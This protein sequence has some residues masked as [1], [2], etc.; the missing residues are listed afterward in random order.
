MHPSPPLQ[1]KHPAPC[2]SGWL[3]HV[4]PVWLFDPSTTCFRK[5]AFI[6]FICLLFK[7][8]LHLSVPSVLNQKG[9][10]I[11]C[12]GEPGTCSWQEFGSWRAQNTGF[13]LRLLLRS[14]VSRFTWC[15]PDLCRGSWSSAVQ[16][17]GNFISPVPQFPHCR[18]AHL[19]LLSLDEKQQRSCVKAEVVW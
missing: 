3:A 4:Y 9:R 6:C 15:N 8:P 1:H 10:E 12:P 2:G 17:G 5:G 13:G 18:I 11:R 19:C 16:M 14:R 7:F